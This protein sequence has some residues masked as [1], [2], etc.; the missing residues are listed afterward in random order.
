ML[1]IEMYIFQSLKQCI[2]ILFVTMLIM[3]SQESDAISRRSIRGG[4]VVVKIDP[5]SEGRKESW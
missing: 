5:C 3:R 2:Y 4:G 1:Y